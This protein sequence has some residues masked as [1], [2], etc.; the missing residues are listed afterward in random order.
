MEGNVRVGEFIIKGDIII[1]NKQCHHFGM[2]KVGEPLNS[3]APSLH[4]Q[5][6][7]PSFPTEL[8]SYSVLEHVLPHIVAN[9]SH[10]KT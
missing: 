8:N 7:S 6:S 5:P 9:D 3:M 1:S 4:Q 2:E 10:S